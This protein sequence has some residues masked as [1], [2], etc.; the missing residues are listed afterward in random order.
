MLSF[1]SITTYFN[2]VVVSADSKSW[3]KKTGI[4]SI[5]C[6]G[7]FEDGPLRVVIASTAHLL[8]SS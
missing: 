7:G 6:S 4:D 5:A 2:D 8:P 1:F 3:G